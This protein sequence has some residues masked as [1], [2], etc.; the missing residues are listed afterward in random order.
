[1]LCRRV[2]ACAALVAAALCSAPSCNQR[3]R[4]PNVLFISIDTLR[5]DHLGMYGYER[6]TSPGIDA[7]AKTA[8]VFES[9]Q[10]SSSWT[11]PS[12]ASLMTSLYSTTHGCW[13]I[14]SRLEPEYETLAESLRDAGWD[15]AMVVPHLFLSAQYGLQQGFTH[16]DDTLIRT[17]ADSDQAI[18]S[19]GI[20]ERG[21]R[22]LE[23]K[24]AA[25]DG[26]PWLLWLHYFDPHDA[27]LPH[28]G[29]SERFGTEKDIDLYDGEIAFT[30]AHVGMV[31]ARLDELGLSKDTIVV[32]VA[33]HGEEFGEHGHP[34]HGYTLYQ[35]AVR[36][37]LIVRVP[38]IAPSR[39]TAVVSGVD[40]MPSLLEA[41]GVDA[42]AQIEGRSLLALARGAT[43]APHEALSEVRWHEGQD[44]R[45]LRA[46]RWKYIEERGKETRDLLFDLAAD[47]R[48][49]DNVLGEDAARAKGLSD[50]IGRRL[51][52]A[53]H[54]AE[55]YPLPERYEPS[56]GDMER[57]K[58]LGYAGAGK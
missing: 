8:T 31:L 35:E 58:K 19:P 16:V 55:R 27:Y 6:G 13:K 18:S 37:P 45:A 7:F 26:V 38:G 53:M 15:T 44:M 30:D 5:A 14:Q 46:D 51:L 20:T 43:D 29:F 49:K 34:R 39:V 25:K 42:P 10:S 33:D 57:L 40:V 12:I 23:R 21:V 17:A 11:L 41:C 52:R 28:A 1:M 48:E 24:A 9:A 22:F 4:G 36:I 3:A 56:P 50:L 47:P 2:T 54:W 32:I